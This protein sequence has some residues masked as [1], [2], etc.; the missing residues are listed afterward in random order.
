MAPR[1]L[2]ILPQGAWVGAG[3][4]HGS[5]RV[6]MAVADKNKKRRLPEESA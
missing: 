6:A 5:M 1:K 3:R 4:C 2:L